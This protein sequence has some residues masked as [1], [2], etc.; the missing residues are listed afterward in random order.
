MPSIRALVLSAA[1][2]T[3][4]ASVLAVG[5]TGARFQRVVDFR[6]DSAIKVANASSQISIADAQAS[7]AREASGQAVRVIAMSLYGDGKDYLFGAIEN[8]VI[9]QRDWPTWT[10]R[11]YHDDSIPKKTLTVLRDLDVE[12]IHRSAA[13]ADDHAGLLLRYIVLQDP[14]VTRYL[15]RDADARL[16][17]R[18]KHA[19]DEWIASGHYFHIVRDHPAHRPEIMGGLWGA[20]GGFIKSGMLDEF[21]SS[22]AEIQFNEDQLFMRRFVWPNVRHNALTHDSYFCEE[23]KYKTAVWRPF[24]TQRL[25][26]RDFPGNKY[27]PDNEYVG[28]AI[29]QRVA[30]SINLH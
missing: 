1:L 24:P 14:T 19:V 10:L 3:H 9:V 15:I 25:S 20:V 12:L 23:P 29:N 22:A 17:Q 30:G 7:L 26:P 6:R 28:L 27:G 11:V 5:R 21:M 18:D 4:L 13:H 8:A 16:S 2:A